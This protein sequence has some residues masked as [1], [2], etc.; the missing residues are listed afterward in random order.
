MK[1]KRCKKGIQLLHDWT[2]A[3]KLSTQ[4]TWE[5]IFFGHRAIDEHVKKCRKCKS[6]RRK[7]V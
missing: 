3:V 2:E 5:S 6:T 4:D 7:H 1:S